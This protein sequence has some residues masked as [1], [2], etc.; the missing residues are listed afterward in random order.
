M[1]HGKRDSL[2][3]I[4]LVPVAEL[5]Y[6]LKLFW[7]PLLDR[8]PIPWPDRRR[9]WILELQILLV[10]VM[11]MMDFL[12][13]GSSQESSLTVGM[14]AIILAVCSAIQDIVINACRAD[15]LQD[16][17]PGAG[18][19]AASLG[20]RAAMLAIGAGGFLLPGRFGCLWPSMVVLG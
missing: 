19:A 5:P 12:R 10:I 16:E 2:G 20:C 1:A 14:A 11:A 18:A 15:L 3:L 17:E 6:T 9:G 4:G 8:W 13:P 7:T